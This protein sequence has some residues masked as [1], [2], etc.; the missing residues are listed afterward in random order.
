MLFSWISLTFL[1]VPL[2]AL[3]QCSEHLLKLP[4]CTYLSQPLCLHLP[5]NM[6]IIIII[7]VSCV[8]VQHCGVTVAILDLSR[9]GSEVIKIEA[10]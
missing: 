9:E 1:L 10:L 8:I 4:P 7:G 2:H 6:S 3:L 5:Y